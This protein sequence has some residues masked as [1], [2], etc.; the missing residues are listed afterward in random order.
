MSITLLGKQMIIIKNVT[1]L[2][3]Y[4]IQKEVNCNGNRSNHSNVRRCER[5]FF[6]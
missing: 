5:N 6:Y 4:E 2:F 3:I 1:D